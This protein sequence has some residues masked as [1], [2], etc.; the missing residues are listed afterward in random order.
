MEFASELVIRSSKLGLDVRE[1]EI[2]YHPRKGESKLSSFADGWR[3]LRFLLVHSPT[4]LFLVPGAALVVLGA[5]MGI[6]VMTGA[7]FIGRVWDVHALIAASL[8]TIVGTQVLQIGMFGRA[9]AAYY[10]GE[11]DPLFDRIRDRLRLEHGLIA[12]GLVLLAGLVMCVV[13]AAA[14][15]SR[16]FG[17]LSEQK[18]AIIGMTLVVVGIQ[19][20][21]GSFFLS[22][23]GLSRRDA[24]SDELAGGRDQKSHQRS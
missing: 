15:L 4:W 16:G 1:V 6:I 23:L 20:V 24:P 9:Y 13:I 3:H 17:E 2:E 12:G 14:W 19:V 8:T 11:H 22:V 5:L 18:L 7:E 10:L 21:F